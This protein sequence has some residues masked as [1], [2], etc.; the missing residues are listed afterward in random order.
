[1][2]EYYFSTDP[3]NVMK[4]DYGRKSFDNVESFLAISLPVCLSKP[5]VALKADNGSLEY[6]YT[7]G[8]EGNV[9]YASK[10]TSRPFAVALLTIS[11][12]L[13][14]ENHQSGDS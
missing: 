2:S 5:N 13:V 14:L 7:S 8:D 1:M 11:Q 12:G 3:Q 9:L 4:S 6:S 10:P